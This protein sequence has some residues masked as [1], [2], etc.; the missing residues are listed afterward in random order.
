MDDPSG[1]GINPVIATTHSVRKSGLTVEALQS[2]AASVN[3]QDRKPV[4]LVEHDHLCPPMGQTVGCEVIQLDDGHHAL[5]GQ[6]DIFGSPTE[7]E[8]PIGEIGL[9]QSSDEHHH[10]LAV[11][12]FH[13]PQN[14]CVAIDAVNLGGHQELEDFF[15]EL[16]SPSSEEFETQAITRRSVIP[17]P[18]VMF[19]LGLQL[20]AAWFGLRIAKAAADS[21]EP[22]LKAFFQVMIQTIKNM[23]LNATPKH[24]PVTYVLQV[25]GKPNLEFVARTRDTDLVIRAMANAGSP[26]LSS[27][28]DRLYNHFNAE[29]IQFKLRDDGSW[30]FNYLATKSGKIVG[31]RE[32]FDHRATVLKQMDK[33]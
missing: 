25:H 32:A 3:E 21:I 19:T 16:R 15:S 5:I 1:F 8:L 23:A 31:T 13:H 14:Y 10:S 30:A 4:I 17:D 24:R 22:E 7:I 29:M 33:R 2:M 6:Y 27:M 12:E 11:G 26:D 9:Q 20:S 18:Q 28:I